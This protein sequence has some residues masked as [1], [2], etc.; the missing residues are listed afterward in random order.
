MTA[1]CG[2]LTPAS[3]LTAG[4]GVDP[5]PEAVASNSIIAP[6]IHSVRLDDLMDELFLSVSSARASNVLFFGQ[7]EQNCDL[8]K[9]LLEYE[10]TID[11]QLNAIGTALDVFTM[12]H[13]DMLNEGGQFNG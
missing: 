2:A 11:L 1:Q 8:Q 4:K 12:Y 13:A 3:S 7:A 6:K 10:Y 9:Y 5:M